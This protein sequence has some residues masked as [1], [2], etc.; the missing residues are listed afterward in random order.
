MNNIELLKAEAR[1]N[2]ISL[3][4]FGPYLKGNTTYPHKNDQLVNTV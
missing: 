3:R 1:L 4:K 2:N